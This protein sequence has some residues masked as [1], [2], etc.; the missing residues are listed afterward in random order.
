M[1]E[2]RRVRRLAVVGLAL[3]VGGCSSLG[4]VFDRGSDNGLE[5]V[6]GLLGNVERAHL[7]CELSR[8]QSAAALDALHA[9][10]APDF[11]GDAIAAFGELQ[12]QLELSI[13]QAAALRGT[14]EPMKDAAEKVAANWEADLEAFGSEIMRA[15]SRERLAETTADYVSVHVPLVA[16]SDAYDLF[17]LGLRDHI[18]YLG[19]ALNTSAVTDIEDQLVVLTAL[20]VELD[21]RLSACMQAA[22]DYV[23]GNALRGQLDPAPTTSS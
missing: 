10:I 23:R 7:E 20:Q 5:Q 9:I 8:S 18:L 15:K 4:A 22:G 13:E 16:A 21:K 11:R 19:H 12:L 14:I 2:K 3:W 6:D 17:N 1:L